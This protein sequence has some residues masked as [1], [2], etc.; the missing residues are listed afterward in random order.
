MD[1]LKITKAMDKFLED[2]VEAKRAAWTLTN[3]SSTITRLATAF[4][5]KDVEDL[6]RDDIKEWLKSLEVSQPAR[7]QYKLRLRAFYKWLVGCEMV[8][9]NP[10]DGIILQ[11]LEQHK[12]SENEWLTFDECERL[13]GACENNGQRATILVG[14]RS[15][16]RHETL[17]SKDVK[18]DLDKCEL[19]TFEKR[20][21]EGIKYHYDSETAAAL[22][23][24][25]DSGG[26]WP[27][28]DY[29]GIN[30]EL[31]Q[32]ARVAGITKRVTAKMLRHTFAC[33]SRIRGIKRE[34]LQRLMHH[35][36]ANTTAI[37]DDVGATFEKEIYKKTWDK[38]RGGKSPAS[39][40]VR[41]ESQNLMFL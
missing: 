7:Q 15:G 5:D 32:L 41:F 20:H 28:A 3:Y 18:F 30:T 8:S 6:T 34:D 29:R 35:A 16:C 33:Q 39:S 37:Y 40:Y 23:L 4:P 21:R 17:T 19:S 22:K 1:T 10:M 2:Y 13:M 9:H 27:Y 31:A 12:V 11:K 26:K 25:F 38:E 36:N 24:Y 14:I